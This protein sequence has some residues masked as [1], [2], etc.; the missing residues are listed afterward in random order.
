MQ[1]GL[2]G[3]RAPNPLS[4]SRVN[5]VL[6]VEAT[7]LSTSH[8]PV[9]GG[10]HLT[11]ILSLHPHSHPTRQSRWGSWASAR[12]TLHRNWSGP[13]RGERSRCFRAEGTL[14]NTMHTAASSPSLGFLKFSDEILVSWQDWSSCDTK[15]VC[16]SHSQRWTWL[17]NKKLCLD[18][19]NFETKLCT[20]TQKELGVM[21]PLCFT[22]F[23]SPSRCLPTHIHPLLPVLSWRV[24]RFHSCSHS[25]P[26]SHVLQVKIV[27]FQPQRKSWL[28]LACD[29]PR[30]GH[31]SQHWPMRYKGICEAGH[32]RKVWFLKRHRASERCPLSAA[33]CDKWSYGNYLVATRGVWGHMRHT[34]DDR[35][36]KQR[37]LAYRH[38]DCLDNPGAAYLWASLLYQIIYLISGQFQLGFLLE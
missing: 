5:Y 2:G 33:G 18:S 21:L 38:C 29:L 15:T 6:I 31:V 20:M 27:P 17:E 34:K 36:A 9:T 16:T 30:H 4:C 19:G 35:V 3:V 11:H 8:V 37:R 32:L 10:K 12:S 7:F 26:S 22:N 1:I 28:G 25:P 14:S 23:C 13:K 24:P